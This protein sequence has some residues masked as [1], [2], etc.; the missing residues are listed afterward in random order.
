MFIYKLKIL[1][2]VSPVGPR[3]TLDSP[4]VTDLS[5]SLATSAPNREKSISGVLSSMEIEHRIFYFRQKAV[6]DG[7]IVEVLKLIFP[8]YVFVNVCCG[9][10]PVLGVTGVLGFVKF[11]G[12]IVDV[13]RVVCDL[14]IESRGTNV[15]PRGESEI[16]RFRSGDLIRINDG[17][18]SGCFG[19]FHQAVTYEKYIVLVEF[20]GRQVPFTVMDHQVEL[21]RKVRKRHRSRRREKFGIAHQAPVDLAA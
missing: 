12:M 15:L 20:M 18:M 2:L 7:R 3:L 6:S 13:S 19:I 5:W 16:C 9:Y 14:E 8:G 4:E 17:A 11:E 21:S 10:E 1:W